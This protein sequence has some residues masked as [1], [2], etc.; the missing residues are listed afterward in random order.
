MFQNG[1]FLVQWASFT[2]AAMVIAALVNHAFDLLHS[3]L[4]LF[5]Y[6]LTCAIYINPTRQ[7]NK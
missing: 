4:F 3:V 6:K 2:N 5:S 7:T 1:A